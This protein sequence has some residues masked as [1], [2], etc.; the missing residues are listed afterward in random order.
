ML[1]FYERINDDDD[2]DDD[3]DDNE[4]IRIDLCWGEFLFDASYEAKVSSVHVQ[5]WYKSRQK[6]KLKRKISN[7]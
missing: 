4:F 3:D 1:H 6:R 2:D 7:G 5:P